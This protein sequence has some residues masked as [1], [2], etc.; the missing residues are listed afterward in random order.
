MLPKLSGYEVCRQMRSEGM[1]PPILIL[2]ARGEESDRVLGLDMG[3]DDG[4]NV[5]AV[6][7]I[8]ER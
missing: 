3:A 5:T 6:S 1:K 4:G 8:P 7:W 2:T